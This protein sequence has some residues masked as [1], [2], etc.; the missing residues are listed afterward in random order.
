MRVLIDRLTRDEERGAV[1]IM[2]A[3]LL[4]V[5]LVA[6]AF[7]VDAGNA[8]AQNRQLSVAADAAALAA[9]AKV[10][11]QLP[12][13]SA[14]T[15]TFASGQ[16]GLATQVANDL[17]A[18]NNRANSPGD[19]EPVDSVTVTCVDEG[20]V[21]DPQQYIEV[22]VENSRTV[23]T[24]LAQLV[25]IDSLQ[26]GARATAR[27]ARVQSVGGLRPWVVCDDTAKAAE[28][29]P[30]QTFVTGLDNKVGVC[31]KGPTAGNWGGVDFDGGANSAKDLARWTQNGYPGPVTIPALLPA[32]PGVSN[33]ADLKTAFGDLIGQIVQFPAATE[34]LGKCQGNN[35]EFDAVGIITAKVCG[36]QYGNDTYNIDKSQGGISDCW[37][38]P[39]T[40][41][42]AGAG[43]TVF[44]ASIDKQ[45]NVLTSNNAD[46]TTADVGRTIIV[47]GAGP[48]GKDFES[49]I[50]SL[51]SESEVRLADEAKT[52]VTTA[53]LTIQDPPLLPQ[54]PNGDYIDHIQFR[55][56]AYTTSSF[57]GGTSGT[58]C[59]LDDPLCVGTVQLWE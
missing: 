50:D 5:L 14:C 24:T 7:A 1:A 56:V 20:T 6:A 52:D 46:F 2:A 18:A 43:R 35:G 45:S 55:W 44:D 27:F 37:Q 10:G 9:A 32:D 59:E 48:G 33:S 41:G 58:T 42:G 26:P 34:C 38:D 28:L 49:T 29:S 36:I 13:G 4:V 11:E 25:G 31:S 22:T 54:E 53:Q 16:T 15:S 39:S 30:N 51:N 8:Y 12:P 23:P 3:L 17:N 21:D 40:F 57:P 47:A 19:N